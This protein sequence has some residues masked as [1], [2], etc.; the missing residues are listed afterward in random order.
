MIMSEFLIGICIVLVAL[1]FACLGRAGVGPTAIDRLLAI[2][3]IGTKTIAI[4]SVIS[5]AFNEIFFLDI[6]IVYAL[7]SFLLTIGV[8]KYLETG[9]IS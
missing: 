1:T 5:F 8:A 2:N 7:I 3:I 4:I 6:A 9:D